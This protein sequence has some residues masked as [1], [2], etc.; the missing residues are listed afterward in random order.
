MPSDQGE[1][2]SIALQFQLYWGTLWLMTLS[3]WMTRT[4]QRVPVRKRW[5]DPNVRIV[6]RK[7]DDPYS[8]TC[9]ILTTPHE[10]S[11]LVGTIRTI[12]GCVRTALG[13]VLVAVG[14]KRSAILVCLGSPAIQAAVKSGHVAMRCHASVLSPSPCSHSH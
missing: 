12:C 4:I 2:V 8:D 9:I 1:W 14:P 6:S 5:N 13:F 3:R 7:R 10:I 11:R